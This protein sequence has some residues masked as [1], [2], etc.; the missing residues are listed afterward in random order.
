MVDGWNPRYAPPTLFDQDE[1]ERL[2][3]EGMTRVQGIAPDEAAL[4][5]DWN[6]RADQLARSYCHDL[7]PGVDVTADDIRGYVLDIIEE[8]PHENMWGPLIKRL[9][10]AG[11]LHPTDRV[12]KSAIAT[13]HA[14]TQRVWVTSSGY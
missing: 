12:R 1:G 3:T 13:R 9:A 2:K 6:E 14:S 11:Y 10:K 4:R 7:P 5:A 8:P